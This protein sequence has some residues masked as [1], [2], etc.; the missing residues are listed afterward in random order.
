MSQRRGHPDRRAQRRRGHANRRHARG[1]RRRGGPPSGLRRHAG[2][3]HHRHHHRPRRAPRA[4]RGGHTRRLSRVIESLWL[5]SA[6]FVSLASL[7]AFRA[8]STPTDAANVVGAILTRWHYI[9]LVA[10]VALLAI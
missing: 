9:A 3:A 1:T 6:V 10:P 4:V 8:L 2:A 7:A 5:A